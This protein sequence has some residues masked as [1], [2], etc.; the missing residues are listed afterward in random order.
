MCAEFLRCAPC[1]LRGRVWASCARMCMC[2]CSCVS[3][4][5]PGRCVSVTSQVAG[6]KGE[7]R[8]EVTG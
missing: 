1:W 2:M 7:W 6:T 5:A 4:R 8:S 3:V